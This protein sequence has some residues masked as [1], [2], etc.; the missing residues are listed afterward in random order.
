MRYLWMRTGKLLSVRVV[1]LAVLVSTIR[2]LPYCFRAS[3][4]LGELVWAVYGGEIW[5]MFI[6][7][8][9]I[10]RWVLMTLPA[11]V[12]VAL[13]LPS[14]MG[15]GLQYT[16]HRFLSVRRWWIG[17]LIALAMLTAGVVAIQVLFTI[18]IGLFF[19]GR[20]L[21]IWVVS[22]DGLYTVDQFRW[23]MAPL[24]AMLTVYICIL[25]YADVYLFFQN[26]SFAML[27]YILPFAVSLKLYSNE[28]STKSLCGFANYLMPERYALLYSW[29]VKTGRI[30]AI[31]IG[32][33]A[34]LI[35]AGVLGI[36]WVQLYDRQKER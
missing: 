27:A 7:F 26:G 10:T 15:D 14:D 6:D 16:L 5:D 34:V 25:M 21:G 19:G 3:F 32:I 30:A 24:M 4:E 2:T 12:G 31:C 23:L 8:Q 33:P 20:E 1:A 22:A 28:E 36:G 17:E 11:L 9:S 35:F 13:V 29:G 18:V